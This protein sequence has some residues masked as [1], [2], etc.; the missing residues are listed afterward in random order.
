VTDNIMPAVVDALLDL[1]ANDMVLEFQDGNWRFAHDKIRETLLKD[2]TTEEQV[3]LNARIA[4]AIES[5]YPNNPLYA[6]ALANHW[7]RAGDHE[8]TI[9]NTVQAMEQV[10]NLVANYPYALQL[11]D[12]ALALP[13]IET[14]PEQ[15]AALCN[16]Q[17][18]IAERQG[19]YR[20]AQAYC[21]AGLTLIEKTLVAKDHPLVARLHNELSRALWRQGDFET[22]IHHAS[23]AKDISQ[24]AGNLKELA[25]SIKNLAAIAD[26]QGKYDTAQELDIQSLAI[27]RQI[28]DRS[29]IESIL[30]NMGV[31]AYITGQYTTARELHEESLTISREIRDRQGIALNLSMLARLARVRGEYPT[32]RNYLEESL[33]ISREIGDQRLIAVALSNLGSVMY[34]EELYDQAQTTFE[35]SLV[36][37]R[38]IGDRRGSAIT[39]N[40]LAAALLIQRK[41]P[42]ARRILRESL[43]LAYPVKAAAMIISAVVIMAQLYAYEGQWEKSALIAGLMSEH[44]LLAADFRVQHFNPLL[45]DLKLSPSHSEDELATVME[46]GKSLDLDGVIRQF[47]EEQS[48]A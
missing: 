16:W 39:L 15:K 8:R 10:V 19:R 14:M 32:A 6:E 36:I 24:A 35:Q 45:K 47:L 31:T 34:V 22:A 18:N 38:E 26:Y 48:P 9:I 3:T 44:P 46:R 5:A 4:R 7:Y 12:R 27:C 42:E 33:V 41:L 11:I 17:G 28:G 20:D 40:Y 30:N 21:T 29:G 23:Q 13:A 25:A 2:L 37:S 1:C 43:E